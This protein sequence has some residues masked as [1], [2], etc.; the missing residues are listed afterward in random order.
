MANHH[1]IPYISNF[2]ERISQIPHGRNTHLGLCGHPHFQ[3]P[4]NL[5]SIWE[6]CP[7]FQVQAL[8][9]EL[10]DAVRHLAHHHSMHVSQV[11]IATKSGRDKKF[12]HQL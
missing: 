12:L 10:H 1:R 9:R 6:R 7:V 4:H 11:H 3:P 5:D 2:V 8:Y